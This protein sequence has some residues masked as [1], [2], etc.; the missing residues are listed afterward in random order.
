MPQAKN[1]FASKIT[2]NTENAVVYFIIEE[3]LEQ[4]VEY[5]DEIMVPRN[6]KHVKY[7]SKSNVVFRF[8]CKINKSVG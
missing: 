6:I 2:T 4:E 5:F 7:A 8:F 3:E 1:I